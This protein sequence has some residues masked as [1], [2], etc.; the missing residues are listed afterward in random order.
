SSIYIDYL[1]LNRPI[2]FIAEDVEEYKQKRGIIFNDYDYVIC[3]PKIF[4]E[5]MF[6]KE[7]LMLLS[8]P[9]Y[10]KEQREE[11]I[12]IFH[13]VRSNFCQSLLD[14]IYRGKRK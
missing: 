11:K 9:G 13:T 6:K 4:T 7:M 12:K 10:F 5:G 1:L 2:M 8:D 3:G 14:E